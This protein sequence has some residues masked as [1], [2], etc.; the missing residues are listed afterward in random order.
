MSAVML[1]LCYHPMTMTMIIIILSVV[2][3][4][5]YNNCISNIFVVVSYMNHGLNK[6]NLFFY[7]HHTELDFVI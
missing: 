1:L 5:M 6:I 3:Y 4:S 7:I 2:L